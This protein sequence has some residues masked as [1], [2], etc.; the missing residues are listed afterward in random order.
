MIPSKRTSGGG[1]AMNHGYQAA[2]LS[3]LFFSSLAWADGDHGAHAPR[4]AGPLW[5]WGLG[6][7]VL[8]VV[9]VGLSL[10]AQRGTLIAE[11]FRGFSRTARWLLLR[12]PFSGLSASL[13][14]LLFTLYLLAV[15][16]DLL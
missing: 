10:S 14:R 4:G 6:G 15:G 9:A 5:V 1:N 8:L 7:V 16:F 13:L 3:A 12:S 2:F 11:R